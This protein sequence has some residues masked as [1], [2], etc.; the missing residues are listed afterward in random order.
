MTEI[1]LE[2]SLLRPWRESDAESLVRYANNRKVWRNMR[3]AFPNPYTMR[4]ALEWLVTVR[5]V[6]PARFFAIDIGGEAIGSIGVFPCADV[7]KRSAEIGYFLGE[8]F[9][10]RGIMTE[11]VEACTR[12][13][14]DALDV[15]RLQ[16]GI[17]EWNKA[18]MRVL[19]KCGYVRE[20]VLRKSVWKDGRLIDSMLYA[21]LKE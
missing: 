7:Y 9:W 21:R 16:A 4:D 14:F 5:G 18:S 19:E 17:F 15:V 8:P 6:S 13:A 11:A 1:Q 2:R 3:D 10:S 20:G 12:H